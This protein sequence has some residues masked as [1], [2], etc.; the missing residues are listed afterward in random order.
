[1]EAA[2]HIHKEADDLA[3]SQI[4][5][6]CGK[7]DSCAANM[8]SVGFLGD[9]LAVGCLPSRRCHIGE[10]GA[11]MNP[12]ADVRACA[13]DTVDMINMIIVHSPRRW[14]ITQLTEKTRSKY[15]GIFSK[16]N[17]GSIAA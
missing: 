8:V 6:F 14:A 3:S 9:V 15:S 4:R 7:V 16:G 1:M 10:K 5:C 13:E 11:Y 2:R 12:I 17:F